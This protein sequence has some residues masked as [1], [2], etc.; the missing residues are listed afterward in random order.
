MPFALL[1]YTTYV[2]AMHSLILS[3][4]KILTRLKLNGGF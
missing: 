4:N 2:P 1:F 3:Y